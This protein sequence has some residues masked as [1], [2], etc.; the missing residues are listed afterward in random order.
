MRELKI[1]ASM[2][3]I[4]L[5]IAAGLTAVSQ[6]EVPE[7]LLGTP[8]ALFTPTPDP[9]EVD[10]NADAAAVPPSPAPPVTTR[11]R[12][13][14]SLLM[15]EVA[16]DLYVV[17]GSGSN[18]AVHVTN[19]GTVLVDDKFARNHDELMGC[20]ARVTDLPIRYV[21]GT[22]HHGDHMGGNEPLTA[23]GGVL[24]L[25]HE[26]V[27]TNMVAGNQPAPPEVVFT[28]KTSLVLG[29]ATVE[30][31]HFGRGHT[32]GDAVV[33]FPELE[34]LHAGDLF[35]DGLPFIDYANGGSSA[36][37]IETL[38]GV[39]SLDFETVIPGHG[40]VMTKRD[41]QSF[42]DRFVTLRTRMTQLI[43]RGVTKERALAQL[44]TRDLEWALTPD[45]LFVRRSF[46]DFYDEVAGER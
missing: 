22:H 24:V 13:V 5:L 8:C 44:E 40:P 20:V 36:D 41:V 25:A 27:R 28:K 16:D 38:G 23:A 21:V 6:T 15:L 42:R 30:V 19:E 17:T 26:N 33:L 18:V 4:V 2:S 12:G 11:A 37:W 45:S 31:H 46:S 29:E 34:V 14:A 9:R 3:G 7:P 32:N 39:L 1:I 43:D 10:E 35:V